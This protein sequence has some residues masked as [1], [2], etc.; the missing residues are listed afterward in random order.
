MAAIAGFPTTTQFGYGIYPVKS[1][2]TAEAL[3]N[4]TAF[5]ELIILA[6]PIILITDSLSVLIVLRAVSS[7]LPRM[8]LWLHNKIQRV[9]SFTVR[10]HIFWVLGHRGIPLNE[11]ADHIAKEV[12]DSDVLLNW[13][14]PEVHTRYKHRLLI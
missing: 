11:K 9:A 12:R 3:A 6:H 2:F 5:D 10:I 14:S 1:I 4:G 13:I 8:I 7:M